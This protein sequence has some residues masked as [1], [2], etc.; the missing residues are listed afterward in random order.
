MNA[1][2]AMGY[3]GD[4]GV[5]AAAEKRMEKVRAAVGPN[6]GIGLDFHGRVK[7]PTAKKL[8]ARLDKFNPLFFEEPVAE[9]Q[10]AY[11]AHVAAATSTPLATGERMYTLAQFRD[12]L[13]TRSVHLIQPDCSHVAGGISTMVKIARLAEA[14]DV[15]FAPHCPLGPI[16]L[17]SCMHVDATCV[18]FAFQE[19]S[20]GIHYNSEESSRASSKEPLL[21]YLKNPEIFDVDEDGYVALISGPGLGVEIDEEKVQAA[22]KIGHKWRDREWTLEDGTPTTW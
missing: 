2:G 3:V 21:G 15:A 18:N 12:L 20:L 19:M 8:C 4:E 9:S 5:I 6:I 10:N 14:Y 13:E 11:L 17:A 7:V 22:S 16:A 1:C